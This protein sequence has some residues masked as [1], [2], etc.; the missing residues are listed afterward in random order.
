MNI[1]SSPMGQSLDRVDGVLKVTG[2][3]RYAGEF[4][5]AGLLHGSVVS[6]T[7][8]KGRVVSIDAS[9][10]LKV[11]GVAR[12]LDH[13]NRPMLASYDK[14]YDDADAAEGSPF[15]PLYNDRVLYSGQP[16]AL[17]IADTL[18]LA[19]YAGSLIR[20]EYAY[21]PHETDLLAE[22]DEA[23]TA[24][25]ETPKPRGNFKAELAGA[26]LSIDVH[27]STPNE[28]HN[29]MEPHAST[30][31]YRADGSLQIHDKTQGLQNCQSYVQKVFGLEKDQV[32][33]LAAFVGGA[34]GSG[35]RPQY[36]LPLAVMAALELKRSVR[37]TLTR[38]QMFTFGYRPR[39]LQRLRLG[40]AA[41]G[42]LVA[43]GH[44]AIGQTSRFEDFTEHVV[45]WSGMLYACDNVELTY[46]L[47]PLDV[48]TPLDMRAP[49]AA[50]GVNGLECAMDELA[51]A[52]A[53]DPVQLR[54]VNFAERNGNED[55]PYS[56]KELRACYAQGAERF[57]WDQ[58][59]PE[60]RS[61]RNGRQLIGWGMAG[62]V[63]ESM[64]MKASAKAQIDADGRLTVS[65]A[66]TDIG[67]GT[68][69]VMT[70]I[71]AASAGV[72]LENVTFVLGDSSLP[73]APLQGGSF[74]VSSVGT[75]VQ[76]ACEALRE[77]LLEAAR[78]VNPALALIAADQVTT[79]EGYLHWGE[80]RLSLA[81]VVRS[82]P[83]QQVEVLVDA[84]PDEKKRKPY[85]TA[86]HSAVFVEVQVDEDLG[87][88]NVS[89]V[90]SAIAAGQVINLKLARSQIL[91]GVVWGIGMA[92]HEEAQTDH[93]LGR[94]MNHSLAEY[95]I[96]V[97][98]DIGHIEVIFVE[99]NDDIVN[100]LG[101]KGVGEI[102]IC[103]VAAAVANAIYH[104]T[105]KRIRDFPITLDKLI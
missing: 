79:A 9:A 92:L 20:I 53:I 51:C 46:K 67:T 48:Y 3:A 100:A 41:N 42:R 76:Q 66:T 78:G 55:K 77:K 37:V 68:Y 54:L 31:L 45:E 32:R 1:T 86:T 33:I 84:K 27:Y 81:E 10:A 91:G 64:Q 69:T 43:V 52:L 7:I 89:R 70:Q 4:P 75:A 6:S 30:V 36:Q 28:Y 73:T 88:V 25:A 22:Q 59:N 99:E 50:L 105:G 29:P 19:R 18:E 96:P 72:A 83:G 17:V 61:M 14:D 57:G 74:T 90:V 97:N 8:A 5:E 24:P 87:T 2:Q 95:H 65:S 94:T 102:G 103:G 93:T 38:Q 44:D 12:V 56:S 85:A 47:A 60:P 35:L 16:L 26:A 13:R 34:F 11:P 104:A 39:T 23:H 21:E 15:R 98:A 71:A 49:G 101:S 40:A 80:Q 58:R 63:W 82:L 62:G